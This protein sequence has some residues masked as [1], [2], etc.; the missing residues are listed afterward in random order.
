MY[1]DIFYLV[2]LYLKNDIGPKFIHLGFG[3]ATGW[4][5][6]LYLKQK[7]H[8]NWGLLGMVV[9]ITTPIVVWLS[10]SVY[11]DLGM[12]FFTT[13]SVLAFIKWRDS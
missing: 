8:R 12:T 10:T 9:F 1:I 2:C 5:I 4:M 11:V 7:L 3:L 13:G 6:Y